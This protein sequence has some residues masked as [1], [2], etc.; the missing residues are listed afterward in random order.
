MG[1][2][3]VLIAVKTY[4]TL[5]DK[6]DELVC[7]AGFLEDGTWIRLYPIPFRK[8]SG[9]N[10]YK[11]WEWIEI[12]VQKNPKDFRPESYRPISIDANIRHIAPV[13][14]ENNW[15]ERRPLA[16]KHVHT[17]LQELITEAKDNNIGTSLAV[18]KPTKVV[19]FVW[20]AVERDWDEKKIEAVQAHQ[21]Q[22]NLFDS[23]EDTRKD[24]KLVRKLPYE[25]SYVFLSDDGKEHTLMIEDWELG[26]LYWNCFDSSGSEAEALRKV[27]EKYF[28]YMV[29]Q[30]DLHF[31]LGTTL[32]FHNIAPNPFIIIGTFYPKKS[33]P[34]NQ[35]H[36]DFD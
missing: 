12:D 8:L 16:L 26:M 11:K 32:K 13:G 31:F 17:S 20:K 7:T 2:V 30:C 5:S 3:K 29:G 1:K 36:F 21:M 4:P 34:D 28:D 10:Q 35:L 19:N 33:I 14:T 18:F 9:E 23:L 6:Y 27:K 15:S 24:F 25:F 22:L